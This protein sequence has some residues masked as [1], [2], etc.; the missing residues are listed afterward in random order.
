MTLLNTDINIA[1]FASG[2]G[3]N[4][5]ALLEH[6]KKI[7]QCSKIKLIITDNPNAGIIKKARDFDFPVLTIPM[8]QEKF[9]SF[10]EAKRN[11]ENK[12]YKIL[13]AQKINWIMLAGY[14][15]ILSKDFLN[16]FYNENTLVNQIVNIHPSLLPNFPGKD[17]YQDAFNAN[18][19]ESGITIH[20]VDNGV[21]TG[22]IIAQSSFQRHQ[23]DTLETFKA[24]G[25]KLEHKLYPQVLEKIINGSILKP[26]G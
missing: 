24:R 3:T 4:A 8:E 22:Q 18:V 13:L 14:M 17:G 21:D 9:A 12:I 15:R 5:C 23:D 25:Q 20:Y 16:K 7:N 6:A 19:S 11:Q 10:S 26:K 2:T 1:I